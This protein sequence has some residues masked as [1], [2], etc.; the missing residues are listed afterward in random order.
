MLFAKL[1]E[2]VQA[3]VH[4]FPAAIKVI[5]SRECYW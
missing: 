5:S 1:M 3:T 4:H 2:K